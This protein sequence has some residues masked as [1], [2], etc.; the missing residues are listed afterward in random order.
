MQRSIWL[1]IFDNLPVHAFRRRSA[2]ID[3]VVRA[4]SKRLSC[5][6][7]YLWRKTLAGGGAVYTDSGAWRIESVPVAED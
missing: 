3:A 6:P 5:E 7:N 2:A 4:I 1:V